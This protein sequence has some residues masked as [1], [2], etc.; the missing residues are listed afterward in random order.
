MT[1]SLARKVLAVAGAVV[2]MSAFAG[3]SGKEA[4]PGAAT[5]TNTPKTTGADNKPTTAETQTERPTA[6]TPPK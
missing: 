2:A 5:R 1:I 3:C 4:D 6:L